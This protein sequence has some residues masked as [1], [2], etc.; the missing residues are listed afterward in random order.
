[1]IVITDGAPDNRMAVETL[2]RKLSQSKV[3]C[4]GVGIGTDYVKQL[5]PASVVINGVDELVSAL[6]NAVGLRLTGGRV[7]A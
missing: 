2:V 5:F 4:I 3:E 1:M 6:F 7:A